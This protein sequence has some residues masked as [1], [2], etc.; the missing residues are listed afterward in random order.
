MCDPHGQSSL[1]TRNYSVYN[2]VSTDK[3]SIGFEAVS[4]RCHFSEIL[5]TQFL[6]ARAECDFSWRSGIF[7][8]H[9]SIASLF[10]C[11]WSILWTGWF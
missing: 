10:Q 4:R 9:S 11:K 8:H 7:S 2:E 3:Y 5:C 6:E 1:I